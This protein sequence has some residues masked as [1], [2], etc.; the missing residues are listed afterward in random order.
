MTRLAPAPLLL[1][2]CGAL[3]CA[4][5]DD[6]G[7]SV[8][9]VGCTLPKDAPYP[10]KLAL[11]SQYTC[12]LFSDGSIQCWG[13]NFG[14]IDQNIG[15]EHLTPVRVRSASCAIDIA[16]GAEHSCAILQGGGVRCWGEGFGGALGDGATEAGFRAAS[17]VGLH[18][19]QLIFAGAGQSAAISSSGELFT[20][21]FDIG[22]RASQI[23]PTVVPG[24]MG[25]QNLRLSPQASCVVAN[26]RLY[27]WGDDFWGQ[28][29]DG[30]TM[31]SRALRSIPFPADV[32]QVSLGDR[33]ACAL[34][35]SGDVWCWGKENVYGELGDDSMLGHFPPVRVPLTMRATQIATGYG[36]TCAVYENGQVACWGNA[37]SGALGNG[38]TFQSTSIPTLMAGVTEVKH[39]VAGTLT[40][41]VL[42]AKH[43]VFVT[44]ARATYYRRA[45]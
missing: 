25:V 34:L 22:L 4:T 29:G 2:A 24:L 17:A 35:S 23:V 16:V 5:N 1:I 43:E 21:G 42:T 31:P 3:G 15:E 36:H 7:P 32:E 37:D 45:A 8:A 26:H 38:K 11:L 33:Y 20:W 28:L 27:C 14:G 44:A 18:D 10:V 12:A 39:V 40:T 6:A 9:P 41:C 30:S 19:A 13:V